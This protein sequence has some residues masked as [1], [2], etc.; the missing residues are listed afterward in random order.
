MELLD[1][2]CHMESCFGPFVDIISAY[3]SIASVGFLEKSLECFLGRKHSPDT[4]RG[5]TGRWPLASGVLLGVIKCTGRTGESPVGCV[6]CE[7]VLQPSLR[8]SPVST[9]RV[10][11]GLAYRPVTLR[12]AELSAHESGVHRMRPVWTCRASGVLQ[13]AIRN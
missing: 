2:V 5:G 9:R 11:C 13:V 8:M 6:R 12:F 10:R 7:E 4:Q 1:D 3:F